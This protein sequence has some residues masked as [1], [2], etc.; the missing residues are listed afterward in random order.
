MA[1]PNCSASSD[2]ESTI[3]MA[4]SLQNLTNGSSV[5]E[6]DQQFPSSLSRTF[7][8]NHTTASATKQKVER[9]CAESEQETSGPTKKLYSSKRIIERAFDVLNDLRIQSQ[10]CDV[11]IKVGEDSYPAHR[12]VLAATSPYFQAMFTGTGGK[13]R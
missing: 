9:S 1:T 7:S 6:S 8:N 11:V 13:E 12:A 5:S 3:S 10:L 4:S 2:W